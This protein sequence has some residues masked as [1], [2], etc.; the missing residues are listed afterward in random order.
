MFDFFDHHGLGA[1]ALVNFAGGGDFVSGKGQQLG[2]LATG[3]SDAGDRPVDDS[4][5]CKNDERR[6]G[7]RAGDGALFA[8]GFLKA[9]GEGARGI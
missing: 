7:L 2:I 9:F 6:A 1:A 3:R 5:V 8:D 4:V